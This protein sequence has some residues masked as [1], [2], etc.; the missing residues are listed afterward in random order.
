[1]KEVKMFMFEGCPHCQ[2]AEEMITEIFAE[3]PEYAR[4][5]FTVIDERKNPE[6]AE[7]YNYYYVPTFYTGDV[8]MMEGVPT[9]E[10]IEKVFA[11]AL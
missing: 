2:R 1:M 11:K 6:I 3:H 4:I 10:A 5:P 8:K 9:K 7:E